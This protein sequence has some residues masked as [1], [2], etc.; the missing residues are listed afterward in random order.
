MPIGSAE[1][2][3]PAPFI[4]KWLLA[5]VRPSCLPAVP[6]FRR[7]FDPSAAQIA[8]SLSFRSPN[9]HTHTYPNLRRLRIHSLS[10]PFSLSIS[11]SGTFRVVHSFCD[12]RSALGSRV[13]EAADSIVGPLR[14][15]CEFFDPDDP[16]SQGPLIPRLGKKQLTARFRDM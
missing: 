4:P 16:S 10:P 6:P 12:V 13:S 14:M 9:T 5:R 3:W 11:T 15:C 7:A 8:P 1:A 2:H